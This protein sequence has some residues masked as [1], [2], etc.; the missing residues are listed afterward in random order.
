MTIKRKTIIT[1]LILGAIVSPL[2]LFVI[3][4]IFG[5]IKIESRNLA[6]QKKELLELEVK[7]KNI[8][9]F[10]ANFKQYQ[11]NLE[12]INQLF[13][14]I[15]EPIEFIEFLENEANDSRLSIEVAPPI[16]RSG[17]KDSW[18]AL[19]FSLNLKGSSLNFLRFLE[20]LDSSQHLLETV[21]LIIRDNPDK[22]GITAALLIKVYAK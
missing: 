8:H 7:I 15:S 12:K 5:Q 2:I 11:P 1:S 9:D 19:D 6:V 17:D 13:V 14:N 3:N 4:P 21:N 18:P 10:K 22:D 20:R 16:L